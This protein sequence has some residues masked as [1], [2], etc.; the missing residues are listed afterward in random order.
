MGVYMVDRMFPGATM[1]QLMA[2]QRAVIEISQR[3]AAR[4]ESIRYL[5]SIYLPGE[6]RCMCLF[7]APKYKQ[8]NKF[9]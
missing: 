2:A 5:R 3:F 8:V 9:G 4:G 6:S 7:E 1:D